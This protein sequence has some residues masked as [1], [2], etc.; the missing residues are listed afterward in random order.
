MTFMR[1]RI[2][3]VLITCVALVSMTIA[4]LAQSRETR[5]ASVPAADSGASRFLLEISSSADE[6][7]GDLY[8][9]ESKKIASVL[10]GAAHKSAMLID[11]TGNDRQQI[12]EAS[13]A[14][15]ATSSHGRKVYT[16]DW[17]TLLTT[18]TSERQVK[19]TVAEILRHAEA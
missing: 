6:K 17:T 16:I 18:A 19:T 15:I 1:R 9:S 10:S 8:S 7:A 11:P 2:L 5:S 4:P 3:N 13:A 14:R 12:I